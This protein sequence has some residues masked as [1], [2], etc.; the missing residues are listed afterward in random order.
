MDE[1]NKK[2]S[3]LFWVLYSVVVLQ[4]AI[5]LAVYIKTYRY[6]SSDYPSHKLL[7]RSQLYLDLFITYTVNILLIDAFI[8]LNRLVKHDS[9]ALSKTQM[10]LHIGAFAVATLTQTIYLSSEIALLNRG[11]HSLNAAE[12]WINYG[13][14]ITEIYLWGLF[15]STVPLMLILNS[16]IDKGIAERA[17]ELQQI[18]ISVNDDSRHSVNNLESNEEMMIEDRSQIYTHSVQSI[19]AQTNNVPL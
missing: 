10:F 15:L 3:I 11:V 8:R 5:N 4:T 9:L 6:G 1:A 12:W 16:L 2:V 19:S 14:I 7:S 18:E 13:K 17:E